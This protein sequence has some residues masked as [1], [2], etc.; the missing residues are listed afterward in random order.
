M[1]HG[2]ISNRFA[3][4]LVPELLP[5]P[6]GSSDRVLM[7]GILHPDGGGLQT[8]NIRYQ[9][10]F[11]NILQEGVYTPFEDDQI[12]FIQIL[13]RRNY[14]TDDI[15]LILTAYLWG[16][17]IN[18]QFEVGTSHKV[19]ALRSK[20]DLPCLG[21]VQLPEGQVEAMAINHADPTRPELCRF[22][23]LRDIVLSTESGR[24]RKPVKAPS[25]ID[26]SPDVFIPQIGNSIAVS[27]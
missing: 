3:W 4:T 7:I 16:A 25:V 9:K 18:P 20:W 17:P 22:V 12:E 11:R 14:R 24:I 23:L 2:H 19:V 5:H 10:Y 8:T 6:D 26:L 15:L 27:N 21:H 1:L 13:Q